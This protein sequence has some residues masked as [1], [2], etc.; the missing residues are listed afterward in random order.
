MSYE[1]KREKPDIPSLLVPGSYIAFKV[2]E[3]LNAQEREKYLKKNKKY[4]NDLFEVKTIYKQ[5]D[6]YTITTP[7]QLGRP[8]MIKV[9]RAEIGTEYLVCARYHAYISAAEYL[10]AKVHECA[11]GIDA[12][13]QSIRNDVSECAKCSSVVTTV[14]DRYIDHIRIY[15]DKLE[16]VLDELLLYNRTGKAKFTVHHIGGQHDK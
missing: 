8:T 15:T 2:T 3:H 1:K 6:D 16:S 11:S 13:V 5:G 12:A 7:K 4:E 14:S 9:I 10:Q